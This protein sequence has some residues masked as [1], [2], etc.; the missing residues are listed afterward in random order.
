MH[1]ASIVQAVLET[2]RES[3]KNEQVQKVTVLRLK[4]GEHSGVSLEALR[5]AFDSVPLTP[6][7]SD[8]QLELESIPLL[9]KCPSCET[10]FTPIQPVLICPDCDGICQPIQGTELDIESISVETTD[11]SPT[12]PNR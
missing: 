5:F 11:P 8:M 9:I 3:I 2:V 10:T 1:E 12:E 4:I 6:P 7:F